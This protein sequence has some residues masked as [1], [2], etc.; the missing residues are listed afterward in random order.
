MFYCFRFSDA[1]LFNPLI[2]AFLISNL[3]VTMWGLNFN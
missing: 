3:G 1:L 2:L